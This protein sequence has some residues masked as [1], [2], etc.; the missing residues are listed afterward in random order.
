MRAQIMAWNFLP[1]RISL[2][3]GELL[4]KVPRQMAWRGTFFGT[5]LM[6]TQIMVWPAAGLSVRAFCEEHELAVPSFYVWQRMLAQHDSA[7]CFVPVQVTPEPEPRTTAAGPPS[8]LELVLGAG[9]VLCV[10]P[11]F[12][13]PTLRRLLAL[14][15]EGRS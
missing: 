3:D 10:A 9:R 15:V 7:V 12:D 5:Q 4:Q 1:R 11:G 13:G 8:S 2:T 6:H 14:L